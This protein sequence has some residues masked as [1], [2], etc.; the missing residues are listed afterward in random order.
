MK[1]IEL[2][3]TQEELRIALT[4]LKRKEGICNNKI[5]F[6]TS[7][8]FFSIP[9]LSDENGELRNLV[10]SLKIKEGKAFTV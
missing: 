8:C 9:S 3:R 6:I 1:D 10:E 7:L 2:F 4:E 5:M